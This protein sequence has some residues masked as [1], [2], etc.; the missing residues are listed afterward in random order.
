MKTLEMEFGTKVAVSRSTGPKS[1]FEV[2]I[3]DGPALIHSKSTLGHGKCETDAELDAVIDKIGAAL[4][5]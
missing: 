3:G 5:A 4:G 1:C 2:R